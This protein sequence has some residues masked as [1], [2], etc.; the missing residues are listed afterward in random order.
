M[1]DPQ[2]A[3]QPAP[4]SP[5]KAGNPAWV[6]GQSQNPTGRTRSMDRF[7]DCLADF[8]LVHGR[9]PTRVQ[10][11]DLRALGKLMAAAE[12]QRTTATDAVRASNS[13]HRVRK[14]LGLA[15]APARG[16]TLT[17]TP[18]QELGKP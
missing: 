7:D 11:A 18:L 14:R 5:R 3:P 10:L 6:P 12:S 17:R 4:Q 1:I 13:A 16:D 15:G 2:T 8:R 9:E